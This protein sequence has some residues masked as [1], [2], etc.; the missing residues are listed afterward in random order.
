MSN[1]PVVTSRLRK[2]II[3]VD[4]DGTVVDH[5][6][7]RIGTPYPDALRVLKRLSDAGV[8][9]VL[10]TCRENGKEGEAQYLTYAAEFLE[11]HGI[12]LRSLNTNHDEDEF[13]PLDGLRR[14]IYADVYIDDRNFPPQ[15]P[16]TLWA[17]FEGWCELRGWLTETDA[18]TTAKEEA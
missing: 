11:K 1:E 17:D 16:E 7:P 6:F 15:N 12:V 18:V 13:R 4:F 9:L 8:H 2:P 10:W 3:G 5:S 14:K